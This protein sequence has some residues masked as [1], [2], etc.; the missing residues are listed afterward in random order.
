M[1]EGRD[2]SDLT[3]PEHT[4]IYPFNDDLFQLVYEN[5]YNLKDTENSSFPRFQNAT[6]RI[7][8]PIKVHSTTPVY[9]RLCKAPHL[10]Q[11]QQKQ[12]G[13][14]ILFSSNNIFTIYNL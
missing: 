7:H 8:C 13:K 10:L 4:G 9:N 14:K 11:K 5:I 1:N 3:N 2:G 6:G 12:F